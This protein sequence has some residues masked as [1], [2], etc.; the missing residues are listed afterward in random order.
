MET[1]YLV[2]W[3]RMQTYC[4]ARRQDELF[5]HVC[6]KL[7]KNIYFIY[8]FGYDFRNRN[9]IGSCI[10][11]ILY[12]F[13]LATWLNFCY[14]LNTAVVFQHDG[15]VNVWHIV[16]QTSHTPVKMAGLV[17]QP[18]P[19]LIVPSTTLL[20]VKPTTGIIFGI[21]LNFSQPCKGKMF[22]GVSQGT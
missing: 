11:D 7:F 8:F 4:T 10:C 9:L 16:S 22:T 20:R 13:F 21:N 17:S 5:L 18:K 6:L 2:S 19:H 15:S 1:P 12:S 3:E 14:T